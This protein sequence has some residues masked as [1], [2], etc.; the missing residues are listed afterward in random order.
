MLGFFQAHPVFDGRSAPALDP[1]IDRLTVELHT[2]PMSEQND[3]WGSLRLA[4]HPSLLFKVRMIAVRDSDALPA[5][6]VSDPRLELAH[7]VQADR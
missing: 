3:L 6:A 2:L 1:D 5:P 4:Y 7:A